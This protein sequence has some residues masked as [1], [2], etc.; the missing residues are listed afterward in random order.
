MPA[1]DRRWACGRSRSRAASRARSTW[2]PPPACTGP[3]STRPP[4]GPAGGTAAARAGPADVQPRLGARASSPGSITSGWSTARPA[5]TAGCGWAPARACAGCAA[6]PSSWS[7]CPRRSPAA[8]ASWW[9]AG[10]RARARWAGGSGASSARRPGGGARGG[11]RRGGPLAGP[12]GGGRGRRRGPAPSSAPRIPAAE[13]AVRAAA[14]GA[15]W[16]STCGC[17]ARRADRSPCRRAARAASR[18]RWRATCPWRL[19]GR[20][21]DAGGWRAPSWAGWATRLS[22]CASWSWRCPPGVGLP[23]SALNRARRALV[24]ALAAHA[25]ARAA[26]RAGAARAA[27]GR[28]AARPPARRRRACSCSA[29]I[30]PRPGPRWPPAPTASTWTSSS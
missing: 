14:A 30:C 1:P 8:T 28:P 23:T 7:A 16:R 13:R 29:A 24:D 2:P 11:R 26:R 12:L 5:S 15:R 21:L 25:A 27:R 9:P 10:A 18:R 17:R 19:G 6:S 20:P 22:S 3:R 4:G